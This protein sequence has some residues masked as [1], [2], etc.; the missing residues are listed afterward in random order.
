[1]RMVA[2]F[3][4]EAH[5]GGARQHL[6]QDLEDGGRCL[7]VVVVFLRMMYQPRIQI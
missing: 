4:I 2:P 3:L 5:L 6:P 1:M 7:L